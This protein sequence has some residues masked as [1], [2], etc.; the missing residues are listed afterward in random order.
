MQA[1]DAAL[2][3]TPQE[4]NLYQRHLSNLRGAGGVDNP[5]GSR[6]S[7]YQ[8]TVTLDNGRAYTIPTVWDGKILPPREAM[9]RAAK[10]GWDRFPSYASVDE[11]EARYQQLHGYMEMDT[12]QYLDARTATPGRRSVKYDYRAPEYAD[13]SPGLPPPVPRDQDFLA[14]QAPETRQGKSRM[15]AKAAPTGSQGFTAEDAQRAFGGSFGELYARPDQGDALMRAPLL[16]D[17][18]GTA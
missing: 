2:G 9:D 13:A 14:A 3:M 18:F 7:L 15:T 1:A 11:A 17:I 8:T 6:S 5:D 4:K 16:R 12:Q 10:E